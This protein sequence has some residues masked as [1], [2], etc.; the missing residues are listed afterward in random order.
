MAKV[1]DPYG[2]VHYSAYMH[3]QNSPIER[4]IKEA[5]TTRTLCCPLVDITPDGGS[6][7]SNTSTVTCLSC[8]DR[9]GGGW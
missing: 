1:L 9:F 7:S 3:I 4:S 5:F 8:L 6:F 2:V